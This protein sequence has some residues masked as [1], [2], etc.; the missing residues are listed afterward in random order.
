MRV[1]IAS[2]YGSGYGSSGTSSVGIISIYNG[3]FDASSTQYG[4][5]IGSGCAETM[6]AMY[7]VVYPPGLS[8][9]GAIV[10]QGGPFRATGSYGAGIGSGYGN[11]ATSI[12]TNLTIYNGAFTAIASSG[13][14]IGSGC[15]RFDGTSTVEFIS[16]Y[17]GAFT[18][19]G[20]FG[21]GIGSGYGYSGTSSVGTISI[22]DGVF[23]AISTQS[24]AGI[25]SGHGSTQATSSVESITIHDGRFTATGFSGA[26]IGSGH[27]SDGTSSVGTITIYDGVVNATGRRYSAGIGSGLA[28]YGNSTVTNLTI[29]NGNCTAI[30]SMGAGIGSGNG[31]GSGTS[32]V[33]SISIYDGHFTITGH[34]GA[35]IGSGSGSLARVVTVTITGG[36][37]RALS[38]SAAAVGASTDSGIAN[39]RI[40]G[41][42]FDLNGIVGVG[43]SNFALLS[44]LT[45]GSPHLDC[46]NMGTKICLRASS[47]HFD[48]GSLTMMTG[49]NQMIEFE[50]VTFSNAAE[51]YTIYTGTSIQELLTGLPIIHVQF[52]ESLTYQ[53][54]RLI[55]HNSDEASGVF[56]R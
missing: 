34:H 22:H 51:I 13:A 40:I 39:L 56:G 43:A 26:G 3:V 27:G 31:M 6:D 52:A 36:T 20:G 45:I 33:E 38:N 21:A 18:A 23:D 16:I 15:G 28:E 54:S 10:I 46:R 4:A 29:Y 47:V 35:G 42:S 41:G 44:E 24:G 30:G 12:V 17:D 53:I 25:G 37:F 1:G 8:S 55:I 48:N 19:T 5:G 2:G 32:S 50:T 7:D 11:N 9:V 49:A 14:G